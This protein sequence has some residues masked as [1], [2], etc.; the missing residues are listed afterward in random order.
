VVICPGCG[1]LWTVPGDDAVPTPPSVSPHGESAAE[2]AAAPMRIAA[3][4][5]ES[6]GDRPSGERHRPG[7][8]LSRRVLYAQAVLLAVGA[9]AAF[10]GGF[11]VGRGEV[12]PSQP[13]PPST[14]P[15]MI[16]GRIS[17]RVADGQTLADAGAAVLVL[18]SERR[19]RRDA[20][21]DA[22]S[23]NPAAPMPAAE[24]ALWADI[25]SVGGA[26]ART[27]QAGGYELALPRPGKYHILVLSRELTRNQVN[28]DRIDLATL[29]EYVFD[30]IGLIGQQEYVLMTRELT[31]GSRV[32]QQF[33]D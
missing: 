32:D 9:A 15:I 23:L 25:E 31:D 17:I 10:V 1:A 24:A 12:E 28:V 19:P 16:F 33:S 11:F 18:P 30:A 13:E 29:G 26:Y 7:V 20:K 22:D 21:L 6:L 2:T 14:E 3:R 27:D 5:P 8:L 4:E